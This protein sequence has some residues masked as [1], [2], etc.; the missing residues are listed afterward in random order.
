MNLEEKNKILIEY[1]RESYIDIMS[2]ISEMTFHYKEDKFLKQQLKLIEKELIKL[3]KNTLE[4]IKE[5]VPLSYLFGYNNAYTNYKELQKDLKYIELDSLNQLHKDAIEVIILNMQTKFKDV[6]QSVGRQVKDIYREVGLIAV[7][8]KLMEASTVNSSINSMIKEFNKR[9]IYAY[10]DKRGKKYRLDSYCEMVI[11]TTTRETQVLGTINRLLEDKRDLVKISEHSITCDKCAKYQ[12]KIYSLTNSTK[13]YPL[14]KNYI[15][16]HPHC[17]HTLSAYIVELEN[18][19]EEDK[20]KSQSFI[21]NRSEEDKKEYEDIINYNKEL[22][23]DR[24]LYNKYKNLLKDDMPSF[25]GFRKMKKANSVKYKE[26]IQKYK[27]L[28]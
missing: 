26:L 23:R 10:I 11:R 28:G 15:P 13:D 12:G 2:K 17:R 19:V 5:A 27:N 21:D 3:D 24:K 4:W 25:A 9:G 1:Y 8:E 14:Y 18:N 20:K 7:R 22:N 6:I 16:V